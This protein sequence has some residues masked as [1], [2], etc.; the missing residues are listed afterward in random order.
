MCVVQVDENQKKAK[1]KNHT[2]DGLVKIKT[3]PYI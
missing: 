3:C 2:I 1:D